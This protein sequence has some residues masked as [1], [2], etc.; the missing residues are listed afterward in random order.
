[1]YVVVASA[2]FAALVVGYAGVKD[3][4]PAGLGLGASAVR[5]LLVG[6]I[7]VGFAMMAG[8]LA[9]SA[10]WTSPA[11]VLQDGVRPAIG[12]E[13]VTRHPFFTGVVA[14][15]AA[16]VLLAPRLTG[17][18]FFAGFVVLA[19]AG[20]AHQAGKLRSRKGAGYDDYL[21]ST[22][23]VPFVAIA[24]GSQQLRWREIPWIG[25]ALGV[26]AAFFLRTKHEAFFQARGLP[27]IVAVAGGSVLIGVISTVRSTLA[28]RRASA[29]SDG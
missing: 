9:P 17:S 7:V 2:T 10:Y 11:A 8:A 20:A 16:H 6:M 5:P 15:A 29:S 12:L 26:A 13:R 28:R 4:G 18:V 1:M 27:V 22:S 24:R 25:L 14:W 3:S 21:K 23:A 19:V